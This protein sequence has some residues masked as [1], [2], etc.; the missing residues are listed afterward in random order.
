MADTRYTW[1]DSMSETRFAF[2]HDSK[3]AEYD[4]WKRGT[5]CGS[6]DLLT[7]VT[8]YCT[9]A[10][11]TMKGSL[12]SPAVYKD[13]IRPQAL[14]KGDNFF[15]LGWLII[16][17]L[18]HEEFAMVHSGSDQ[19]VNTLVLL[20]PKSKRGLVVFTNGDNGRDIYQRI[21]LHAFDTGEEIWNRIK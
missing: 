19:G 4:L 2:E 8:D 14:V 16:N 3:G 5:A 6:D 9:F 20:L 12:L 13:M 1:D 11:E 21:V 17:N 18:S 15:G 10:V 7:T